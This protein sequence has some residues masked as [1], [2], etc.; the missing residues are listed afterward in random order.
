MIVDTPLPLTFLCLGL[1]FASFST[2]QLENTRLHRSVIA[3][4]WVI[5]QKQRRPLLSSISFLF[6][7]VGIVDVVTK[8]I[9]YYI[10]LLSSLGKFQFAN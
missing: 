4:S 8:L 10:I 6:V 1:F 9:Q 7:A 2:S 3:C 5:W